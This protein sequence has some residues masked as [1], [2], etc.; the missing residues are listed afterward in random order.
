[1]A[2]L[3]GVQLLLGIMFEAVS[4]SLTPVW[5]HLVFLALVVPA[6]AASSATVW[7]W[8]S[9]RGLMCTPDLWALAQIWMLRIESPPSAKKLS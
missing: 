1:M 9:C 5:Y 3:A 4:W 6:T 7:C 2:V 8:N